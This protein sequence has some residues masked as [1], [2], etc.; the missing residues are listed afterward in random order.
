M[1]EMGLDLLYPNVVMCKVRSVGAWR[2]RIEVLDGARGNISE[3][4][5]ERQYRERY[6]RFLE[7]KRVEWVRENKVEHMWSS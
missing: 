4:L 6:A 1:R 2:K 5:R 3:K 7:G